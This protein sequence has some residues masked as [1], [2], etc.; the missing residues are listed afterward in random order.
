MPCST[1]CEALLGRKRATPPR[2]RAPR[3]KVSSGSSTRVTPSAIRIAA[4]WLR[5]RVPRPR[6]KTVQTPTPTTASAKVCGTSSEA[7]RRSKPF[8][9]IT[10]APAATAMTVVTSP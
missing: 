6:P 3:P 1:A 5:M 7:S 10:D 4:T 8:P 9:P 2:S